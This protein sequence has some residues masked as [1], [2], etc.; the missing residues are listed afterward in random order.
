MPSYPSV[1]YLGTSGSEQPLSANDASCGHS[2]EDIRKDQRLAGGN[3]VSYKV[4]QKHRFAWQWQ[5]LP[6]K[7]R[8]VWDGGLGRDGLYALYVADNVMN[9]LVPNQGGV[10]TIYSVRFEA[11]SWREQI[12]QRTGDFWAWRVMVSL[13]EV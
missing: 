6:G 11:N 5:W 13:I 12:V 8:D 9:F 10:H 4:A 3:L 1:F 7:Q 2:V